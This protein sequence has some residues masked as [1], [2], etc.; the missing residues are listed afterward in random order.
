MDRRFMF[1]K[2]VVIRG[3]S[4][5]ATGLYKYMFMII[6]IKHHLLETAW[7]VN[8]CGASLGKGYES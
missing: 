4:A 1:M 8:L 6:I 2:K 3:L 5:P 7:P